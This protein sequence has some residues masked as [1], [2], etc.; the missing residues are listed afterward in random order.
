MR[1]IIQF[2][3]EFLQKKTIAIEIEGENE[4]CSYLLKLISNK[5]GYKVHQIVATVKKDNIN[6]KIIQGWPLSFY[7]IKEKTQINVEIRDLDVEKQKKQSMQQSAK[8]LGKL[9]LVKD[10]RKAE[11][12][13]IKE[14]GDNGED[15]EDEKCGSFERNNKDAL[16]KQKENIDSEQNSKLKQY[17]QSSSMSSSDEEGQQR[18]YDI[19]KILD[20]FLHSLIM[21]TI[22][23]KIEE[24][25]KILEAVPSKLSQQ[26]KDEIQKS[27]SQYIN[28]LG[29][30]G[31]N[32]L[33]YAVSYQHIKIVKELIDRGASPNIP[34]N[35]GWT[36]LQ[37]AVHRN[38]INILKILLD[39]KDLDLNY[40]TQQGTTLHIACQ[41]GRTQCLQLLL[42]KKPD[43][44]IKNA[45]NK[46]CFESCNNEECKQI[47][48]NYS[49]QYDQ[50][51]LQQQNN[52]AFP[53]IQLD[54]FSPPK[55]PIVKGN[56]HKIGTFLVNIKKR[57]LVINPDEG[58]LI[59]YKS[60]QN[61]PLKPIE[62]IPLK[63]I[64]HIQ[65][66]T[67]SWFMPNNFSYFEFNYPNRQ[68][69]G[70]KFQQAAKKWAEY[71]YLAS[72]YSYYVE[73]KNSFDA[74]QIQQNETIELKDQA[75]QEPI[76]GKVGGNIQEGVQSFEKQSNQ[77]PQQMLKFKKTSFL[78]VQPPVPP[79][80]PPQERNITET[81]NLSYESSNQSNDKTIN[82]N[83]STVDSIKV[84]NNSTSTT[85]S[86]QEEENV[87]L[88]NLSDESVKFESFK[89]LKLLGAGSF[90]KVLLAKKKDTGQIY[91]I[92]ALK[93]KPLI[94]KK[95]L[96]YA[97]TEANVLKMCNNPFVLGLHYAFQT[98]NYLYLVLD[99][100]KGGD[101]SSHLAYRR[102]FTEE[103][104]VFYIGELVLAIQYIHDQNVVYRDLK[105]ENI[106]IGNDG[107]IKLADF[108]LSKDN[109]QDN[110]KTKSF[111]GT[112]A[113]LSPEMLNNKGATKASDLY[114]IGAVLYEMLTGDPPYY[115]DD[116]PTMYKKIKE[117]NLHYPSFVSQAARN[118][119]N[120]LLDRNPKTRLGAQNKDQIRKDPFFEGI[121]WD[122]LLN[123]QY[124][125]PITEFENSD[126]EDEL[127]EIQD[128]KLFKDS[129]YE[130][131]NKLV[132]RVRLFSFIRK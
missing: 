15:N 91:A 120:G 9:G 85:I 53:H 44:T 17:S 7:E 104:C 41:F 20:N 93:K 31:W 51:Q 48:K 127:E 132:N 111:C 130:D 64:V 106:L 30:Q 121:D 92:K 25:I 32:P 2:Y 114:G 118:F 105:P 22:N 69:Y 43:I 102:R 123:K 23:G 124:K 47:L 73:S 81:I 89:I 54:Q 126:N 4:D 50:Q 76:K 83:K 112:P 40:V 70:C 14:G 45:E 49:K 60:Q 33:H 125:P 119:V 67:K 103:E 19:R 63:D 78:Q 57:Y 55:P 96:R 82:E 12:S 122:K 62:V 99:Y 115:D 88:G 42:E 100:C 87:N 94:I 84:K 71:L 21:E 56:I 61:Y 46:T 110:Q 35:Q 77:Q 10:Q 90:G 24:V 128:K 86:Q 66:I 108:G 58:T 5:I 72:V 16:V 26:Q 116:I 80:E 95:Q 38:N 131:H 98:P 39:S 11:L 8:Y 113:Y 18:Q 117:G 75:E 27:K 74:S 109:V 101:I 1:I 3:Y 107:H 36:S 79:Q 129:D 37:F 68:V 29:R 59:R 28:Q 52:M 34:N 13:V 97:V 6:V 65:M